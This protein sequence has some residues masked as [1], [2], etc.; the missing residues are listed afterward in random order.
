MK[1]DKT[2]EYKRLQEE[3]KAVIPPW[4]K[5]GPYVCDRSWATVRED[6]SA[7]GDAWNYFPF[8]QAHK[9]AYRWGED[10][11][12]GICDRYQIFVLSFAFWNEKDSI[13]KE[14]LFGLS[15]SKGN[16]G[17]DVKEYYYHLDATPTFSYMKFLYK[18]PHSAFPY[19][20]L[21][22][23]NKKRGT[24]D[25]EYEL[26]DTG[27]FSEDR[28]FD[29][30]IEYAKASC[31]DICIRVEVCNRSS[32]DAPIHLIP[33]LAFRNQWSFRDEPLK[34]PRISRIQQKGASCLHLNDKDMK[35]PTR[36]IFDY[37]L[38]DRYFYGPENAELLFTNNE[39]NKKALWNE[40]NEN[41]Y[42]KDAF[43][44]KIIHKKDSVNPDLVGTKAAAHLFSS[45][46]GKSSKT[47][48]FRVTNQRMNDPFQNIE[49][50]FTKRKEEA[51]EFY[52]CVQ[53][54]NASKEEKKIQRQALAGMLWSQ[55]V[56]LFDVSTWLVGDSKKNPPP[57]ERE[58]IRNN[59]WRHLNSMRIFSMPDKWEYPWFAAWDLAFHTTT[60]ALVDL[61]FA[62]EQL[63]M[64]LFDQFQHPN[65]QIPAYEW[66]FCDVNPPVQAWAVLKIS[67]HEEKVTGSKDLD[68]LEK[69]FHKLLLNFA[70]WVN[71]I[72]ATGKNVFEG[73][74]L[75][76][77]N[78]TVIDRSD[79]QI[80]GQ[81]DEADGAGWMAMFCYNLMKISLI[82][83][84]RNKNYESLATKYFEHFV[85]IA[86][87]LRKGYWRN[88]DMLDE[89][90]CF[91]YSALR[92]KDGTVDRFRIRS[93]VGIIP[94]FASGVLEEDEVLSHPE[95]HRNFHWFCKNR[96]NLVEKCIQAFEIDGKKYHLFSLIS[97][98]EMEKF[99]GYIWDP[100]EFRSDYG[101]RSISKFHEKNPYEFKGKT[102]GYEPGESLVRIK[103]GN[104]NWRGPIWF[105]TSYLLVDSLKTLGNSLKDMVKIQ[106]DNEK[107]VNLKQMADG[108]SERLIALFKLDKDQK[109]PIY[110]EYEKMQN[111]PHF[112]DHLL[113]FEHYHGDTGRGLG[114]SHQTGWSGLV[115]NLIQELYD[116]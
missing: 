112:R 47:F 41:P 6:Y 57:N 88:Y 34:R 72:D 40:E 35:S 66:E 78:I 56:Y 29:I 111:D 100:K 13:L 83:S 61:H 102:V 18:Y 4:K 20:E 15:S 51:D 115:A 73:G 17:E 28:Y 2:I 38:L 62:K 14:R 53:P 86:A 108:F 1:L 74:F 75:G 110:G 11:I 22:E 54:L 30:F 109:R 33:Q 48:Y 77:D 105:P 101:L 103:G 76:L 98:Q 63:W 80:E 55:Q 97:T 68:F 106:T 59:H 26:I 85:Y 39:T 60:L 64:L 37:H 7:D 114:A 70:W 25:L 107:A 50:V 99:L 5:W 90:D 16:H 71:K 21:Y 31:E 113:F 84:K 65:G 94:F 9:R 96:P 42:V 87:A 44:E 52:E 69:C 89:E 23:E 43:H 93:L 82:L 32:K 104:S 46:P 24:K 58:F 92:K 79:K 81:F 95:F 49:K 91:F 8:E 19:E 116:P 3:C 45:I 27:V 36:L 12:A 67:E 10:G